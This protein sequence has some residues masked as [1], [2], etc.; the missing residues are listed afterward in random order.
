[1]TEKE[2][3]KL[4]CDA[5]QKIVDWFEPQTDGASG[6][7]HL[8]VNEGFRL[9][10]ALEV[11]SYPPGPGA[12]PDGNDIRTMEFQTDLL[13]TEVAQDGSWKPR[14]V[15]ELKLGEPTTHDAITYSQKATTHKSVHPYLRY[16]IL[17]GSVDALS[18]RFFRHGQN[19]DFMVSWKSGEPTAKEHG[20]ITTLLEEE[21][22]ASRT[23]EKI[24]FD[25][26]SQKRSRYSIFRRKLDL[27]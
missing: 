27:G 24:L 7:A 6:K 13:I 5:F 14:V 12:S 10:Y 16:G 20:S 3:A 17:I 26:R 11:K 22:N 23:M 2:W 1:M 8:V 18:G 25:T 4:V 21:V 9:A 19:F 15:I